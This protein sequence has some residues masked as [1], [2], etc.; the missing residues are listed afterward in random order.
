[1][2]S[3]AKVR[4]EVES[5]FL[6]AK[7]KKRYKA[8]DKTIVTPLKRMFLMPLWSTASRETMKGLFMKEDTGGS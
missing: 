6:K 2:R 7:E 8:N 5:P 4:K 3:S 1:M